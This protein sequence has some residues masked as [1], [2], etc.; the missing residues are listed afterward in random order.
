MHQILF[1]VVLHPTC[2]AECENVK[3]WNRKRLILNLNMNAKGKSISKHRSQWHSRRKWIRLWSW[4]VFEGDKA[5]INEL[6]G[7]VEQKIEN[8]SYFF[9]FTFCCFCRIKHSITFYICISYFVNLFFLLSCSFPSLLWS[10]CYALPHQKFSFSPK[11]LCR[12]ISS[13]YERYDDK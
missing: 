7:F 1:I 11:K 13:R 6:T 5:G 4:N 8:H 2:S 12:A 10:L 3:M 9:A